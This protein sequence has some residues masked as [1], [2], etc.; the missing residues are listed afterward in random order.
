MAKRTHCELRTFSFFVTRNASIDV[1]RPTNVM[2]RSPE[3][4]R[5]MEFPGFFTRGHSFDYPIV[6]L[7]KDKGYFDVHINFMRRF[8][9]EDETP[10]SPDSSTNQSHRCNYGLDRRSKVFK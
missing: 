2:P 10:V 7:F 8:A 4:F 1:W 9:V 6:T 3:R 5:E